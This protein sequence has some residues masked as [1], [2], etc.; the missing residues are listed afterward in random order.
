[1]AS[2]N[3]DSEGL[4]H[5]DFLPHGVTIHAQCHSILFHNNVHQAIQKDQGNPLWDVESSGHPHTITNVLCYY[6]MNT[7]QELL[8]L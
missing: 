5:A 1:M 7:C 6:Y 8:V 4:I 3:L 2:V